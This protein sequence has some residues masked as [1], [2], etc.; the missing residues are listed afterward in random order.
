MNEA[1][2]HIKG[3]AVRLLDHIKTEMKVSNLGKTGEGDIR[4]IKGITSYSMEQPVSAPT[5]WLL[6][7]PHSDFFHFLLI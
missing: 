4:S 5:M 3:Q 7:F 1:D 2:A 6:K